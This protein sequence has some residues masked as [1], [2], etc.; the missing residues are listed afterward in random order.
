M[1]EG[2]GKCPECGYEGKV[3]DEESGLVAWGKNGQCM[4]CGYNYGPSEIELDDVDPD[5]WESDPLFMKYAEDHWTADLERVRN[6]GVHR[7]GARQRMR[8]RWQGWNGALREV[9]K[10]YMRAATPRPP[11]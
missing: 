1:K 6:R 11:S 9:Q 8:A 3:V 2:P 10:A 5:G 4:Q 7:P